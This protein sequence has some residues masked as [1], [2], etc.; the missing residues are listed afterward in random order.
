MSPADQ[1]VFGRTLIN[2][3]LA[4]YAREQIESGRAPLDD[5][6]EAELAQAI[7]DKLFGLGVRQRLL[8]DDP[9]ENI[10]VNGADPSWIPRPAGPKDRGPAI[11]AT[12]TEPTEQLGT[13]TGTNA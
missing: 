1:R 4:A 8:D 11:D 10:H 6:A 5:V 9:I 7:H 13:P 3:R 2:R 12:H